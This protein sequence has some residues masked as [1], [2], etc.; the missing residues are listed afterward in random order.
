MDDDLRGR[1]RAIGSEIVP[2]MFSDTIALFAPYAPDAANCAQVARDLEYGPHERH[3]L[4]LFRPK[5]GR[6]DCPVVVF[7]HGGGFVQGDKGREN[8]PFYGNFGAWAAAAGF[9]GIAVNYRLAPDHVW[10]AGAEDLERL[11][12]WLTANAGQHGGDPAR[13]FLCGQSAGA[14][15]VASY[16]ALAARR[17]AGPGISGAMMLSGIYDLVQFPHSAFENAYFGTDSSRFAEQ[18]PLAGLV[19]S[20]VPCLFSVAEY[21]PA[22][23]QQQAAL[24]VQAWFERRREYPRMLYL[25]DGNHMSGILSLGR[26]DDALSAELSAFVRKFA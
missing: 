23:F 24:L 25:P 19:E 8:S 17:G 22:H 9:V 7:A 2:R 16:L 6:S 26:P 18:S 11:L 20:D 15:H 21:D 13:V 10:P 5:D 4:D 14:V 3:R 12:D 1:I